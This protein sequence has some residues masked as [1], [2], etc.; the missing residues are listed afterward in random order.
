MSHPVLDLF[1]FL[2]PPT[3][4]FPYLGAI[5]VIEIAMRE[6]HWECATTAPLRLVLGLAENEETLRKAM[7]ENGLPIVRTT[8][9][10]FLMDHLA[11]IGWVERMNVG[12]PA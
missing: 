10:W 8:K 2:L 7:Y 5:W 4:P 9:A 12:D 1:R 3:S 11:T 6:E